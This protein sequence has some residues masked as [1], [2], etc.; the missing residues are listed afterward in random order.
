MKAQRAWELEEEWTG[1][2]NERRRAAGNHRVEVLEKPTH[3][4]PGTLS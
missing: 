1:I 3:A 2:R 4:R